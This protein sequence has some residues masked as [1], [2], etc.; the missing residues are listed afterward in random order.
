MKKILTL[1]LPLICSSLIALGQ[2]SFEGKVTYQVRFIS[3]IKGLSSEELTKR[4]ASEQVYYTKGNNYRYDWNGTI[5]QWSVYR[6]A[7]KKVYGKNSLSDTLQW[8]GVTVNHD[9]IYRIDLKEND[10]TILGYP[11]DR[12]MF[13]CRSGI[14][15]YYFNRELAVDPDLYKDYKEVNYFAY[16]SIAKSLALKEVFMTPNYTEIVIATKVERIPIDDGLF[17]LPEGTA[18]KEIQIR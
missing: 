15:A 9:T 7:D 18:M 10:T 11:C 17:V 1:L 4:C 12:L 6:S 5:D 3:N 2:K 16:L 8:Y 14:Q 13:T